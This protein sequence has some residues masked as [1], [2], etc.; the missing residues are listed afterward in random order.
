MTIQAPSSVG[1]APDQQ[2]EF[3]LRRIRAKR[4]FKISLVIFV[5]VNALLLATWAAL[6]I[7]GVPT[8]SQLWP[9][10]IAMGIW[11]AYV[12][13]QGY[14]AYRGKRYTQKSGSGAD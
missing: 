8:H 1:S 4:K 14:A 9:Y 11:A 10:P 5:S 13:L 3:A 7:A 6:A 2:R 12:A